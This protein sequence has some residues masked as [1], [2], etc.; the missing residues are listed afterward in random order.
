MIKKVRFTTSLKQS[1]INKRN[2]ILTSRE[3]S[4]QCYCLPPPLWRKD[5]RHC[6]HLVLPTLCA[7][8]MWLR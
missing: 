6:L 8:I 4:C 7:W 5:R 3:H 2:D 1:K